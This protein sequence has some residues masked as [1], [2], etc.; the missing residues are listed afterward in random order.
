MVL[1][2][3][4][5]GKFINVLAAKYTPGGDGTVYDG[6]WSEPV[7]VEAVAKEFEGWGPKALGM[8]KAVQAPFGWAM[9][10]VRELPTYVRG[11][12]ALIGDAAHAMVP[13]QGAGVGQAFEDG[14]IL[15]TVLAHPSVTLATLPAALAVYDAVRRPFS[16][17]VQKGS[18]NN[19]RNYQL[20]R[21]GWEDVSAEDSR[22]GRYPRELLDVLAEEIRTQV[23]W[24][25]ESSILGE[26]EGVVERLAA[27]CG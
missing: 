19:G 8:I 26:R 1:Y 25:R 14:Y 6:P 11:R 21:A 13:Y 27:L 15:A 22:A 20:R 5:G 3:I 9:H 7:T 12:A 2:P 23:Q 4:S 10:A 24:S 18:E 17:E 16:Q